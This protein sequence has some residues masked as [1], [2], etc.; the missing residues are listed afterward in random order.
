M[1]IVAQ[2]GCKYVYG[3]VLNPSLHLHHVDSCYLISGGGVAFV[4]GYSSITIWNSHQVAALQAA[5]FREFVNEVSIVCCFLCSCFHSLFKE[6]VDYTFPSSAEFLR[7]GNVLRSRTAKRTAHSV[8]PTG[9][10]KGTIASILLYIRS[11]VNVRRLAEDL[12]KFEV[13]S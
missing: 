7:L 8:A 2:E 12:S 1:H 10:T 3:G 5:P 11:P 9:F 13:P 4:P 6:H